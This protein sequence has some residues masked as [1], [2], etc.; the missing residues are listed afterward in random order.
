MTAE[1][2][3]VAQQ[4]S[5]FVRRVRDALGVS[6]EEMAEKMGC[7]VASVRYQEQ[8]NRLPKNRAVRANLGALARAAGVEETQSNES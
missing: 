1:A 2:E 5:D 6:Q 7:S 3:R 8:N 4:G